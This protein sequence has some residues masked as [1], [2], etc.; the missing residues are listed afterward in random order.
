MNYSQSV[1]A[2][3]VESSVFS[4]DDK[5]YSNKLKEIEDYYIQTLL[6]DNDLAQD[7]IEDE[8]DDIS[9]ASSIGSPLDIK[10]SFA[11][12]NL[13]TRI[14]NYNN[15]NTSKSVNVHSNNDHS[16]NNSNKNSLEVK[17]NDEYI[18]S[19][20]A[21]PLTTEN[22]TKL[23]FTA[24]TDNNIALQFPNQDQSQFKF[25]KTTIEP[26]LTQP[27]NKQL[28]KTELCKTFTTK[29][30]CKY[31][32]KCQFA[33][34]LHEVKFKSRSNN[35]RTKP[36]INWTKL[37]YC[38]YGVRCCFKHGDDRDIEL[39]KKAGHIPIPIDQSN[40]FP[41]KQHQLHQHKDVPQQNTTSSRRINLHP[42]IKELQ[43]M[44][45]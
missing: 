12:L 24:S 25:K 35:Y 8:E 22:L 16:N 32:N 5:D 28:F 11:S 40:P 6:N 2:T 30:Y 45:W 31:G 33:H 10:N 37:G 4:S 29:G 36:C 1:Y 13:D 9:N 21:L 44:S 26:E 20:N 18:L 43:K 19:L 42:R 3:T 34:G 14:L 23:A 7:Q 17:I 27:L 15:F 39:Y 38:P 41:M